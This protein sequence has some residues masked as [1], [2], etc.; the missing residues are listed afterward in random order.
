MLN[1]ERA[2][3]SQV[4]LPEL[5]FLSQCVVH[6]CLRLIERQNDRIAERLVDG[7]YLTLTLVAHTFRDEDE[8]E[9]IRIISARPA[10]STERKRYDK[11]NSNL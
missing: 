2:A 7:V 9:V 3:A 11:E 1:P 8:I 10:T 6:T 4:S 5:L